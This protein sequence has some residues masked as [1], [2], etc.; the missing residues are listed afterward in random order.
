MFC[1]VPAVP[2]NREGERN[3]NNKKEKK[4]IERREEFQKI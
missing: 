2:V 1:Y 4:S 3:K